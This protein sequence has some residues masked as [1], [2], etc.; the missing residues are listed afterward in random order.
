MCGLCGMVRFEGL[1]PHAATG[2]EAMLSALAHRGPDDRGVAADEQARLGF[3]RLAIRALDD[4]RQPLEEASGVIV[5]CNG[6]IDNHR[7]LRA[8]LLARGIPVACAADVAVIPAL[9]RALGEAF[10][11]R[12]EGC[13]ALAVW[14][15]ARGRLLLGRDRCG[16]RPLFFARTPAG[17][18]FASELAALASCPPEPRALAI[19]PLHGFLERSWFMAPTSPF[20]GVEKVRPGEMVTIGADGLSR[21]RYWRWPHSAPQQAS[22]PLAEFDGVFRE[23]VWKQTDVDVAFGL[24]LSGGLD[25][26]LIAA[27]TR[28]VRPQ[29]RL[30]GYTLRFADP[31]CDEGA[32]AQRAADQLGVDCI[33]VWVMPEQ[34]P[35]VL[36]EL[37][38]RCGEPVLDP[39]WVPT[40]LL[41]RRAAAD[42]RVALSGDG[43]DELFGGYPAYGFE[44]VA[45][46]QERLVPA[47]RELMRRAVGRLPAG[48]KKTFL[49]ALVTHP[50]SAD[51]DDPLARHLALT[52]GLPSAIS[53][54]L[55]LRS[56]GLPVEAA[57][58][59]G[60]LTRLQRFDLEHGL[61][62]GLMTKADRAGM[63]SSLEIRCPF[64]D[65]A[66]MA[67]AAGLPEPERVH[68]LE[69]KVFLKRY[70]LRYLPPDIV[71][72]RKQ[73][74]MVP[75]ATWLRG[76]L[77]AWAA[78]RLDPSRFS[79]VGIRAEV[80][81]QLLQEH[82]R[83]QA[84]HTRALWAL[85]VLS[86]WLD[87]AG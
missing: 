87:W 72:R 28:A 25:S 56:P 52:I 48:G 4:G 24:F 65:G 7:E 68:G 42:I 69:T 71:H 81:E 49:S 23:A 79:R 83:R 17:V 5:V 80:P 31:S 33:P 73:G 64:L 30:R 55:G 10:I 67:F 63:A 41:A 32:F 38:R 11:E 13:F 75:L 61:A 8:W 27:I 84:D 21:R 40:A 34:V 3:V 54:R 76:P 22:D 29:T 77:Q 19:E 85:I 20:D 53:E 66:V 37:I 18:D 26:S 50:E 70:A 82:G 44:E 2:V 35:Q 14:D 36:T 6:E 51:G 15:P 86:E 9:Y 12:L 74:L 57:G 47:M 39:A 58:T 16:E 1:D 43:G 46:H 62:E 78:V 59:E 45:R 60:V